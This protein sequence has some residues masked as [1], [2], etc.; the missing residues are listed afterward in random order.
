MQRRVGQIL[1][2]VFQNANTHLRKIFIPIYLNLEVLPLSYKYS[3]FV[4]MLYSS[5]R[6]CSNVQ[7]YVIGN[8]YTF[9]F[10]TDFSLIYQ[11]ISCC[12]N[13]LSLFRYLTS[14]KKT[15]KHQKNARQSDAFKLLC[16]FKLTKLREVKITG[17]SMV[18]FDLL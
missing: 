7:A 1:S 18:R 14:S 3:N 12:F 10:C 15:Q 2:S 13:L 11:I 4:S 8:T 17:D 6:Q 9:R 16:Y 5:Q